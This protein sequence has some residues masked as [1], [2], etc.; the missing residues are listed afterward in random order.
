MWLGTQFLLT[1]GRMPKLG[2]GKGWE[3]EGGT[4]RGGCEIREKENEKES[5]LVADHHFK[6]SANQKQVLQYL[7]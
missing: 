2:W 1:L 4:G 5:L 6:P 7:A 3:D